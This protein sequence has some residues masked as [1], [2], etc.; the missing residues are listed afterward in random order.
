MGTSKTVLPHCS[1]CWFLWRNRLLSLLLSFPI[2]GDY[3]W[4]AGWAS[5]LCPQCACPL[6]IFQRRMLQGQ[7][8]GRFSRL[9]EMQPPNSA[10]GASFYLVPRIST[11]LNGCSSSTPTPRTLFAKSVVPK[12]FRGSFMYFFTTKSASWRGWGWNHPWGPC[13]CKSGVVAE[14]RGK[15]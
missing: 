9:G 2:Q 7:V 14:A 1:H 6:T 11:E 10:E 15:N 13:C 4:G 8:M 3:I 5:P 12:A